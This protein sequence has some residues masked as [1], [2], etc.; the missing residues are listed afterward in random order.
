MIKI[1]LLLLSLLLV[2]SCQEEKGVF[3]YWGPPEMEPLDDMYLFEGDSLGLAHQ[4]QSTK[5]D[6]LYFDP[7]L[8]K[9]I[10]RRGE[11]IFFVG[12]DSLIT[13][14]GYNKITYPTNTTQNMGYIEGYPKAKYM[15]TITT[16]D[17]WT[18][19]KWLLDQEGKVV[20]KYFCKVVQ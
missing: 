12:Q 14:S 6:T 2:F 17:R 20:A 19:Q 3:C 4:K 5:Y 15:G 1:L 9:L 8:E 11:F 18:D 7:F 13:S 16:K 10:G